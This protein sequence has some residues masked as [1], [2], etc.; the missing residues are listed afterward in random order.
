MVVI[1]LI[2][3]VSGIVLQRL[4]QVKERANEVVVM[5]NACLLLRS[6]QYSFNTEVYGR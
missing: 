5:A 2:G 1:V 6:R 4:I 3:I